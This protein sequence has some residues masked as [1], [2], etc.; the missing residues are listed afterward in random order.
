MIKE[1]L[2]WIEKREEK[3]DEFYQQYLEMKEV[4]DFNLKRQEKF[5]ARVRLTIEGNNYNGMYDKKTKLL[6][7]LDDFEKG[8][9]I[10]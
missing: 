6:E 4:L 9:E 2:D 10:V 8:K 5:I 3:K 7:L 1:I